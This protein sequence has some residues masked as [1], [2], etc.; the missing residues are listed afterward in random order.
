MK[1]KRIMAGLLL[2][3]ITVSMSLNVAAA[4]INDVTVDKK[5]KNI[6]LVIPDGMSVDGLTLARWYSGGGSLNVDSLASGLVRTYSSDAPIAD[7]APAGTAMAT[8]FKSHT[9]FVGVLPDENTMPG[10]K[11]IADGDKRKPVATILEAARLA[12][13]ATGV[14]ATSEIMHATPADFT[15]HDPSRKNYDSISEQQVYQGIDVV[16]GSGS[17]FFTK[18]KRG[19]KEDLLSVIKNKYQYVTTP[20]ELE[21]VNNGKLWAM[22]APAAM[23][24]DFDRDPAKEPSLAEMTKK[25][26]DILSKDEDG[27]FLM[28]EASKIDWAAHANDPI[29][30][31]SD[32]LAYD[33]AVGVALDFARK[34]GSTLVISATD[35][36]N[37]GISIGSSATDTSYDKTPLTDF[38]GPLKKAS[39]TGEGIAAKLDETHSNAAEVLAKFYGI[40]DLSAEE[41]EAVKATKAADMNYTVGPMIGKRA[42]LGFTTTGHT[43]EDVPLYVFA[44]KGIDQLTGTVENTDIAVYMEKA[45]GLDLSKATEEL[46]VNA[47]A[48]FEAKGAAVILDSK[49]DEKNPVLIVKKDSTELKLPINKNI[50]YLNGSP[51]TLNGVVVFNGIMTYVPQS[52]VDLIK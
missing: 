24:Y 37:S 38:I 52:A 9:G 51:V 13:K 7:S 21:K 39:L 33:K 41:L 8:G 1:L 19:D 14:I 29:G 32:I 3:A 35:H 11:R 25:A 15:A 27:F 18:E 34:D 48:A 12:G 28:V 42:K 22:F 10:L 5:A 4:G 2:A 30:I 46:F 20:G 44:P 17:Q 16:I 23:A 43:G 26:I 49:T 50:A 47:K 31:I 40:T 36:G 45:A 6:I